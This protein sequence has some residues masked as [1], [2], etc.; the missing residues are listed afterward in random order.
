MIANNPDDVVVSYQF[1]AW[2]YVPYGQINI[3]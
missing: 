3:I 1:Y 2:M